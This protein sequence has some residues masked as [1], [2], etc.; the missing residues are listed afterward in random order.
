M[1][2]NYLLVAGRNLLRHRVFSLLNI[3]GLAIGITAFV[4]IVQYAS[5]ELS[6]DGFHRHAPDTYRVAFDWGEISENGENNSVYASNVPALGPAIQAESPAVKAHTRLLPVLTLE[7]NCIFTH[8]RPDGQ[9]V[10][11]HEEA[12]YYA[13]AAFFSVFS[14]PLRVG[15]PA[16]VLSAPNGIVLSESL[17][18]KYFG[19]SWRTG[20]PVGQLIQVTNGSTKPYVVTGV[21]GDVPA[22][23]H[24]QF[25]FLL[26]FESLTPRAT[27]TSWYMSWVYTYLQLAPGTNPAFLQAAL[28]A[29]L[30]KHLGAETKVA[31][32][33]QPLRSIYLDSHLRN[34]TSAR[35]S[36]TTVY[37]L[38][39]IAVII[40]GIA[41]LN[42]VNLATAKS[43][44][45]AKEVGVRKVLGASRGQLVRQFLAESGLLNG[46]SLLVALMLVIL[47]QG[48]FGQW[49]GKS[50]DGMGHAPVLLWLGLAGFISLG[51]LLSGCYPALVLSA[52]QPI[53]ALKGKLR[54]SPGSRFLRQSL[55][56]LQFAA[57][58]ILIT[59]TLVIQRQLSFMES[60]D[61]GMDIHQ[62]LVIKAPGI[63][64]STL[65]QYQA[66]LKNEWQ[67]LPSVV[68]AS[69]STAIPG[70]EITVGG[71][72]KKANG[73]PEG[74][75]N[76]LVVG[77]DRDFVQAYGLQLVAGRNFSPTDYPNSAIINETTVRLLEF[78]NNQAALNQPIFWQGNVQFHVIGVVKDYHQRALKERIE[79]LVL[80]LETTPVGYYTLHLQSREWASTLQSVRKQ[81]EAVFRDTPFAYFFLD[82]FFNRQYQADRQFNRV[83][84]LFTGLA[85]FV[86]CLGLF[87]LA[88]YTTL[89]R[90]KEIGIRKVLGA[91]TGS[92]LG[93]LFKEYLH[94]LA[95]A[96]LLALPIGHHFVGEWL[97][98]FAYR[99]DLPFWLWIVPGVTITV[100]ALLTVSFHTTKAALANPVKS[101]RAE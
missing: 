80:R 73:K 53:R 81:Y 17:A 99:V 4:L 10:T 64:D 77:V 52:I 3:L 51:A 66:V 68:Q 49:I 41:W 23:S 27:Q 83:V 12:G 97:R 88:S 85:I 72:L 1:F 94:L 43:L 16:E 31:M 2:R 13:S 100:V 44:E 98:N 79:P 76:A 62:R 59:G 63:A 57:S 19:N 33:L 37:F 15:K 71:E 45:R 84:H 25:D 26:S 38:L 40:V 30:R 5:F 86:A 56:V 48:P 82:D 22:N 74:G 96:F 39:V 87:G 9:R 24:L 75:N 55:V 69:A 32:F 61:L 42:Y 20:S 18:Q 91:S 58:L 90:T 54:T 34:E 28:P 47:L 29:F 67:K 11:F 78:K 14:F 93:L 89:Q 95:I 36:R 70:K 6:Y 8:Q 35:G 101:L 65:T 50:T 21:F 46:V 7:S 60:Q 92:M